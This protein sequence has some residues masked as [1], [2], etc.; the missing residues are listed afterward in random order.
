MHE[1]PPY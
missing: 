1:K